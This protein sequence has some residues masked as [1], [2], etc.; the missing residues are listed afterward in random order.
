MM[1]LEIISPEKVVLQEEVDEII[2]PTVN[3]QIGI[4]PNHVNLLT[5]IE[6]GE[7]I[8]KIKGKEH[9]IA[10]T[11]GFL[12]IA[13]NKISILAD[14]AIRSEEINAQKALEAQKRAEDGKKKAQENANDRDFALA[15]SE[16][17][18]SMLQLKVATR[19]KHR[20]QIPV[21]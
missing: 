11:G 10:I 12:Q 17:I 6:P 1:H 4:L 2:A 20:S 18:K 19:R 8:V 5:Q 15:E 13:N 3:G 14:Y 9:Y 16:F 21:Q 7:M